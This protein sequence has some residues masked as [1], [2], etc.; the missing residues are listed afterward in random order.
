M[1]GSPDHGASASLHGTCGLEEG[2]AGH[3]AVCVRQAAR[4]WLISSSPRVAGPA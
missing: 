1:G 3:A 2:Q 4:L